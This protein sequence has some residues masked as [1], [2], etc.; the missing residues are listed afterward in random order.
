MTE[1]LACDM[2]PTFARQE[3]SPMRSTAD[4]LSSAAPLQDR[5]G[6]VV[7]RPS[8]ELRNRIAIIDRHLANRALPTGARSLLR[9]EQDS[10]RILLDD[11]RARQL[12]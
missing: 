11:R 1:Q 7:G 8:E 9:I 10:L 6:R 5:L 12:R 2:V 4:S 3:S